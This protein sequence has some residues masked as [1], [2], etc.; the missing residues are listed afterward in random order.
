MTNAGVFQF[1][2]LFLREWIYISHSIS[3][4][5]KFN[6][7]KGK[8][9]VWTE[10]D[11]QFRVRSW[12]KLSPTLQNI[13]RTSLGLVKS[14]QIDQFWLFIYFGW[15]INFLPPIFILAAAFPSQMPYPFYFCPHWDTYFKKKRKWNPRINSAIRYLHP[16]SF[17]PTTSSR[18]VQLAVALFILGQDC[19]NN[20]PLKSSTTMS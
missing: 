12:N 20:F 19:W 9:V 7:C 13:I 4:K 11:V 3:H 14:Q 10:N 5:K 1:M 17:F 8:I 2:D 6:P 18:K 15:I 16:I